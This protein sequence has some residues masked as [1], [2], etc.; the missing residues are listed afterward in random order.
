MNFFNTKYNSL[1][2]GLILA[3]KNHYPI[4]ITPDMIWLLIE[5]GFVRYIEKYKDKVREKFVNFS[6]KKELKLKRVGLTPTTAKEEDWKGII[7]E[8][9]QQ[10]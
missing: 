4:T 2:Q 6:G 9:V 5:Q 1:I 10:I 7:D 8:F 3:Y